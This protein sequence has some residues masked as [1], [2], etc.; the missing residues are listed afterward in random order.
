M[1][2]YCRVS[3]FETAPILETT[4]QFGSVVLGCFH[5][6]R[7]FHLQAGSDVAR[8]ELAHPPAPTVQI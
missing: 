8:I 7:S 1:L 5:D 4:K 2:V 6:H 3:H